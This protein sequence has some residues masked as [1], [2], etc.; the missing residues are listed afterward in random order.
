MLSSRN[1]NKKQELEEELLCAVLREDGQGEV[2][3]HEKLFVLHIFR[4][5]RDGSAEA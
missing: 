4:G 5:R 2:A 1:K 3:R